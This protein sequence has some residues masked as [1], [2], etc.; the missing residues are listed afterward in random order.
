[1][2]NFIINKAFK[3]NTPRWI[4]L[5]I[6]L[7]LVVNTFFLSYLI[8]FNFSLNFDTNQLYYQIPFVIATAL[9]SF[10]LVGSYKGIIR[11]TGIRDAFNIVIAASIIAFVLVITIFINRTFNFSLGFTIPISI[12]IIHLLLNITILIASRFVFK[13]VY[14]N[15]VSNV[16]KSSKV[17]IYGAGDL[18]LITYNAL[19]EDT[20]HNYDIVA[21]IDDNK[22]KIG[23]KINR[24]KVHI[25]KHITQEFID[26]NKIEEI[27]ISI[28]NINPLKS[29]EIVD[30]F[31]QLGVKVK[32]RTSNKK[33]D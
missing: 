14:A 3:N 18:G 11:H 30:K 17:L 25:S 13:V 31:S 19:K 20:N 7:Y 5:C 6:D 15:L 23:K 26:N 28:Q 24:V 21:F 4:V 32:N 12:I 10:L 33:M 29:I 2:K 22:S 16:E 9:I 1:M 27:I 8:R